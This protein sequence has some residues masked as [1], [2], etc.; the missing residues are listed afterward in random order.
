MNASNKGEAQAYKSQGKLADLADM[1]RWYI[2]NAEW[3]D[4]VWNDDEIVASFLKDNQA[5]VAPFASYMA[6]E[7][8]A[9]EFA[10]LYGFDSTPE[11]IATDKRTK[12]WRSSLTTDEW[13]W[14]DDILWHF[15]YESYDEAWE[16]FWNKAWTF[17]LNLLK[18]TYNLW[19]DV[20]NM[21]A[22]PIDTTNNLAKMLVGW[23]MNL[24]TLDDYLDP[25]WEWWINSANQMADWLWDVLKERYGSWDAIKNTAY[26]DPM[27][28]VSDIASIIE[29]W[30]WLVKWVSKWAAIWATKAWMKWTASNLEKTASYASKVANIAHKADP[31]VEIMEWGA[32]GLSY[33]W[34]KAINSKTAWKIKNSATNLTDSIV[35]LDN[36]TKK[37]IQSNPYAWS[38]WRQ[39]ENYIDENGLP[40]RSQEVSKSLIWDLATAVQEDLKSYINQFNETWPL[41]KSLKNGNYSVDLTKAEY[42]AKLDNFLE[43]K[44]V[45]IWKDGSL[46]FSDTA[47]TPTEASA[48]RRAYS[49]LS[50]NEAQPVSQYLR[51]RKGIDQL[52]LWEDA[53]WTPWKEILKG[54]REF[55]NEE[56][57]SQIQ[58]LKE[59]DKLYSEQVDLLNKATEWLV[60][61]DKRRFG[62]YRDNFNQILKNMDTPNRKRLKDR[63]EKILPW[64][65]QKVSAI[66]LM[67]KLIDNYYRPWKADKRLSSAWWVVG[68]ALG[69]WV[70]W[71]A[72]WAWVWYWLSKLY[73]KLACSGLAFFFVFIWS[74]HK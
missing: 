58:P 2:K 53:K 23:V 8:S 46:D 9:Y 16:W 17:W 14:N 1:V 36:E 6:W 48:I 41:Y 60:Y 22:N 63:L 24:T 34:N 35:W 44:W 54:M 52:W 25:E 61:R 5:M 45:V 19:S 70:P 37:A 3:R 13:E 68:T 32:K 27:G 15:D 59:L 26:T 30:A 74:I 55:A 38:T 66:N 51:H 39:V 31:F 12:G 73:D 42:K 29:W 33:V 57:H 47:V 40:T 67:P 49:W 64:L 4:I 56:A 7:Q 21:V 11:E 18:S 65:E 50:P 62:E 28:M 71:L 43:E 10:K 20:V 72:V 69:G